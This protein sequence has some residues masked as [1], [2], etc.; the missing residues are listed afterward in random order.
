MFK[1]AMVTQGSIYWCFLK[2]L[3]PH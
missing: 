3:T 2:I 1:T